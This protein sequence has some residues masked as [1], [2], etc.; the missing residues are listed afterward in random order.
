[1]YALLL[2]V[3]MA[4]AATTW[5]WSRYPGEWRYAFSARHASD[6]APL[7]TCRRDL[8]EVTREATQ[9]ER[10]ARKRASAEEAKYQ[11]DIRELENEITGLLRPGL[12]SHVKGPIGDLTLYTHVVK[13]A[14]ENPVDIPLAGLRATFSSDPTYMIDLTPP[15]ARTQ[16]TKYPR[17]REAGDEATPFFT[18]EQLSDFTLEIMNAAADESNFRASRDA[19]LPHA[20]KE[21][22]TARNNSA[23]RDAALKNLQDV[24]AWQKSN[25]LRK[26]ALARL[27]R[28]RRNW[29]QLTG[30]MPPK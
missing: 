20:R 7:A 15:G 16:R 1:M 10:S 12:G 19:R 25:P 9:A 4:A 29:Q 28:E 17:R 8:R 14:G 13:K 26:E 24:C 18:A 2:V 21:L 5:Y 27:D 22:E 6:R 30:K 11:Q 3:L 23:D